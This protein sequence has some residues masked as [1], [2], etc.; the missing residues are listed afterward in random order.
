MA[1]LEGLELIEKEQYL[2]ARKPLLIAYG[3]RPKDPEILSG[4]G[5][6]YLKTGEQIKALH[7]F[8]LTKQ[9]DTNLLNTDKWDSLIAAS[10]YWAQIDE[11][12]ILLKQGRYAQAKAKFQASV[13]LDPDGV[14]AYNKLAEVA[15]AQGDFKQANYQYHEALKRGPDNETALRGLINVKVQS[16]GV[17]WRTRLCSNPFLTSTNGVVRRYC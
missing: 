15:L 7:Y 17:L 12:N 9:Y 11:G 2:A 8:K 6:S 1:K 14:Y 4:L 16:S 5:F 13:D 3:T 10:A